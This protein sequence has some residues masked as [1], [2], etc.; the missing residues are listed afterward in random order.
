MAKDLEILAT[1]VRVGLRKYKVKKNEDGVYGW[2]SRAKYDD[3]L[4]NWDEK[5]PAAKKAAP[6]SKAKVKAK[7]KPR[8]ASAPS[9]AE[10]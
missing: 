2:D 3:V 4:K 6:K 10:A 7:V 9:H 8:K 5:E 1:S